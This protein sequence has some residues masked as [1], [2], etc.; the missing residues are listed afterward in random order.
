[1][2]LKQPCRL[3][4]MSYL[5]DVREGNSPDYVIVGKHTKTGQR[6]SNICSLI[7]YFVLRGE[8]YAGGHLLQHHVGYRVDLTSRFSKCYGCV[9][10][11]DRGV[12]IVM[13][14]QCFDVDMD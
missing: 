12:E 11:P 3:D 8:L 5:R 1:M 7:V 6:G 10:M 2:Y 14:R 4:E 9:H 13:F